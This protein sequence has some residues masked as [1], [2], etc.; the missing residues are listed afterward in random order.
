MLDAVKTVERR[1]LAAED[2]DLARDVGARL[3]AARLRTGQTQKEVAGDR[4]TKA[5]VSA[6]ENGLIKPSMAALN[7]LATRL[8]TTPGD[9]LSDSTARWTL[10]DA[11]LRLAAG[12]YEPAAD[13]FRMLLDANPPAEDRAAA[14]LGLAESLSRLGRATEAI[15]AATEANAWF[16]AAGRRGESQRARYWLASAHHLADN[17]AQA[18]LLLEQI[19]AEHTAERPLDDDLRV[20][21]LTALA[22]VLSHAGEPRQAIALLEEARSVGADID[23]RRRATI[24]SSLA[25]G[26]RSTGDMEAAIT[27][28]LQALALFRSAEAAIEAASLENELALIYLAIGNLRVARRHAAEARNGFERLRAPFLLAHVAETEAQI[29][30][31]AGTLDIATQKAA[32]AAEL[33]RV[34]GNDKAEVSALL[35]EARALRAAG[36]TAGASDALAAAAERARSGPRPRLREVLSEWSELRAAEGDLEAAYALSREALSLV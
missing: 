9:L 4:Y 5:Y 13:G 25:Q 18:K 32:E 23:D 30:L 33:A 26:Y 36:D 29:A 22:A 35:T 12:E 6:L 1:S 19:L 10:L 2:L 24:H 20:R 11:E 7:Y 21:L 3:R 27:N 34:A 17:P 15:R 31:A 28:G 8:G 16:T 14:L